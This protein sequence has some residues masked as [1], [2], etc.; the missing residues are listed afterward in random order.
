MSRGHQRV[1]G[2]P[3]SPGERGQTVHITRHFHVMLALATLLATPA[4]AQE[5]PLRLTLEEAVAR[6][7]QNSL[8]VTELQARV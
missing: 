4:I 3:K 6:A 1:S 5:A 8:R 7:E 2:A